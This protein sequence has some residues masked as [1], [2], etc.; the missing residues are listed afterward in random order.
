[1]MLEHMVQQ[2]SVTRVDLMSVE[3]FGHHVAKIALHDLYDP[4][5][6]TAEW[7]DKKGDT[8]LDMNHARSVQIE[9]AQDA[10]DKI[11]VCFVFVLCFYLA[12]FGAQIILTTLLFRFFFFLRAVQTIQFFR[13]SLF[14]FL[15]HFLCFLFLIFFV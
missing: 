11:I 4:D 15:I 12:C 2:P 14:S 9:G 6:Q 5:N 10:H 7:A 1:M 3:A 8:S 13:F